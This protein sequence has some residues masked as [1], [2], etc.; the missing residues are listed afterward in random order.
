MTDVLSIFAEAMPVPALLAAVLMALGP[1]LPI[2]AAAD[3]LPAVGALAL[4]FLAGYVWLGWTTL[5]P[6]RGA[7]WLPYLAL[8]AGF[9]GSIS[10]APGVSV[11]ERAGLAISLSWLAAWCLVPE[12]EA[13]E[14]ARF[15]IVLG[16]ALVT[17]GL[18]LGLQ[19]VLKRRPGPLTPLLL[20][21]TALAGGLILALSYNLK[22]GQIASVLAAGLIGLA[23]PLSFERFRHLEA[24]AP[25]WAVVTGGLMFQGAIAPSSPI[26][27][28]CHVAIPLAP[29]GLA[30]VT[31]GPPARWTGAR[32]ALARSAAVALP[33]LAALIGAIIA[34]QSASG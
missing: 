27:W 2:G 16:L 11:L 19:A 1:R 8:A 33:A 32:G 7:D 6:T 25:V 26:P 22:L 29:L 23:V 30:A 21:G 15:G 28:P 18:W 24:V 9:A 20:A 14:D 17:A 4:A 13:W 12:R 34:D 10:T 31:W 3:R 5:T